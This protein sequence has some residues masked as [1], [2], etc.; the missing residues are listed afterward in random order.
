[1]LLNPEQIE[2]LL[3]PI[4][5][6]FPCGEDLEYDADFMALEAA[7]RG[8]EEQQFGDTI[9]PAEEPDWQSIIQ[10][11]LALFERSKDLRVALVLLRGIVKTEGVT[12]FIAGLK[13]LVALLD[14]YWQH[15][16]PMLDV[17]DNDDPTMRMNALAPLSDPSL[18]PHDLRGARLVEE[19]RSAAKLTLRDLELA[20]D[21]ATPRDDERVKA[22]GEVL[23]IMD[24][25]ARKFPDGFA[26]AQHGLDDL[27]ALNAVLVSKLDS[28]A[29]P[30]FTSL[31]AVLYLLN[32]VCAQAVG[33]TPEQASGM[34]DTGATPGETVVRPTATGSGELQSREDALRQLD[35]VIRFLLR[36]EPGNPAPLLIERAKRL[37]GVSFMDIIAELVPEALDS[38]LH[39]TGNKSNDSDDSDDS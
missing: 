36:T 34:A 3:A 18:L 31:Q 2:R 32:Q 8:K 24:E 38:V 17:E 15:V 26:L 28:T 9:I 7:A 35:Q 27:K 22:K 39:V 12:G 10:S 6:E 21:K 14:R 4:S 13:L 19:G 25:W 11:C 29:L 30:D 37:I 1:M 5:Q 23:A 16:H 20:Y 33:A